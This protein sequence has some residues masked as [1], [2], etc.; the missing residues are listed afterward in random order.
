MRHGRTAVRIAQVIE[1]D[2]LN[3]DEEEFHF[4]DAYDPALDEIVVRGIN[5]MM[6]VDRTTGAEVWRGPVEDQ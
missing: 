6:L 2:E 3:V 1:D 5:R 4:D